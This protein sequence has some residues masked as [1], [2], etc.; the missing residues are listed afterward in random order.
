MASL[1][2]GLGIRPVIVSNPVTRNHHARPIIATTAMYKNRSSRRVLQQGKDLGHL[3]FL[4]RKESR[5]PDAHILHTRCFHPLP[6]PRL[7]N[8]PTAQVEYC[9]DAD[10]CE[11][12]KISLFR[13]SPAIDVLVD[14]MEV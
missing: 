6:L 5:Q 13:L 3:L 4:R 10:V 2:Q 1:L 9:L 11:F 7:V 14:T 8:H 12:C